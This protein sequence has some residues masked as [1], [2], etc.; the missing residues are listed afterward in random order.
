M[1][2]RA[3]NKMIKGRAI[4]VIIISILPTITTKTANK[5]AMMMMITMII[6]NAIL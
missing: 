2:M 6:I 4:L 1:I 5:N 3:Y